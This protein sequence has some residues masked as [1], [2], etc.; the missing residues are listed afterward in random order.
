MWNLLV[1]FLCPST[2]RPDKAQQLHDADVALLDP[3]GHGVRPTVPA[4]GVPPCRGS[5][6]ASVPEPA[7]AILFLSGGIKFL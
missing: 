5:I 3:S 1:S 6:P 2:I 4:L 7:H